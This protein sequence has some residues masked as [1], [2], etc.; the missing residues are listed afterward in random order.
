VGKVR[1]AFRVCFARDPSTA[2]EAR[3]LAYLAAQRKANPKAAWAA[4]ARVLM[5][6][7]EFITRE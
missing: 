4:V 3:V 7:D 5:N 1:F 6:L 2:E